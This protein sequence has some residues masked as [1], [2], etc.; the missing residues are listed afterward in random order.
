MPAYDLYHGLDVDIP[1]RCPM[2]TVTTIHDLSVFDL[3]EVFSTVRARG[4]Q[5]LVA[6]AIRRAD[7]VVAVSE[8]TADRIGARFGCE[9]V[10]TRLAPRSDLASPTDDQVDDVCRR[11]RLPARF[12]LHVGTIEPRKAIPALA[13]SCDRHRIPLVLAGRR[14]I[15]VTGPG[16]IIELG[17]VPAEDLAPLYRAATVVAYPSRYEGFGLPPIEAIASGGTV[18]A[19]AVGAL[20]EL[21]GSVLPLPAPDDHQAFDDH[22]GALIADPNARAE[23]AA[24][25]GDIVSGLSWDTTAEQTLDVYRDLGCSV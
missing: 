13:Q 9:A 7:V 12:V 3:P 21:F 10:V 20:P 18:L 5:I 22:L 1:W 2:P 4:E 11:H 16:E 19:T 8:F 6:R 24:R 17:H 15:E 23:L 25:A 14:D